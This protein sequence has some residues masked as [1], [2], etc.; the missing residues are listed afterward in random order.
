VD[1]VAAGEKV[2]GLVKIQGIVDNNA[3]ARQSPSAS[4]IALN[5]DGTPRK[6]DD[7]RDPLVYAYQVHDAINITTTLGLRIY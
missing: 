4:P 6:I 1:G 2:R 7:T 3:I 5:E